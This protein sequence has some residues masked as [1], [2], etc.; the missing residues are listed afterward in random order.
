MTTCDGQLQCRESPRF[1]VFRTGV[2]WTCIDPDARQDNEIGEAAG[3]GSGCIDC[4][5]RPADLPNFQADTRGKRF[6]RPAR[7]G[8]NLNARGYLSDLRS[9][10][11]EAVPRSIVYE[12]AA[13]WENEGFECFE[14]LC[15]CQPQPDIDTGPG[16]C[17]DE[18]DRVTPGGSPYPS[19]LHWHDCT[20]ITDDASNTWPK[21]DNVGYDCRSVI[22]EHGEIRVPLRSGHMLEP[23]F[24]RDHACA[25]NMIILA[26]AKIDSSDC[27]SGYI[28]RERNP[29]PCPGC[30]YY[31]DGY[32][33]TARA[34]WDLM[35]ISQNDA[36]IIIDPSLPPGMITTLTLKNEILAKVRTS[37]FPGPLNFG[38]LSNRVSENGGNNSMLGNWW[39][40]YDGTG[41]PSNWIDVS[42]FDVL[43]KVTGLITP[44]RLRIQRVMFE[45]YL[46][47]LRTVVGPYD[48]SDEAWTPYARC[49][50][51]AWTQL[52]PNPS[53]TGKSIYLKDDVP[54]IPPGYVEWRGALGA[55][56]T[57]SARNIRKSKAARLTRPECGQNQM[58][59]LALRFLANVGEYP[60][61]MI[62]A[63]DQTIHGGS[64]TFNFGDGC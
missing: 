33:P 52:D 24:F 28:N 60:A 2:C 57:P 38:Q 51:R 36:H 22:Y 19:L 9:M 26:T 21:K 29:D 37:T 61:G 43:S 59:E 50:I 31:A 7:T 8:Q 25:A 14:D 10:H 53:S 15:E 30:V 44:C 46:F 56:S 63:L 35:R 11:S 18:F 54:F 17:I 34:R 47:V 41:D 13:C 20:G 12:R 45:V 1:P 23:V 40:T 42:E 4:F 39:R 58:R 32:A 62:S 3:C 27:F 49:R 64:V 6:I 5:D 55:F 48:D 16:G